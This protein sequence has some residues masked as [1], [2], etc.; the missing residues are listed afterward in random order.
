MDVVGPA[1]NLNHIS[2]TLLLH[3]LG[4]LSFLQ[5]G[6]LAQFTVWIKMEILSIERQ[7]SQNYNKS[8]MLCKTSPNF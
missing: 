1:G 8:K 5:T 7:K 2:T 6:L 3:S 4:E